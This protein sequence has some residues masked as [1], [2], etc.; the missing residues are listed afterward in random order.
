MRVLVFGGFDFKN[1]QLY[2]VSSYLEVLLSLDAKV[3]IFPLSISAKERIGEY[4][5]DCDCV[6][7]CGGGDVH[8]RFYGK[9]PE[10]GIKKINPLRDEI[11]IEAM[12]LSYEQNKRVLAICRGI[13]VMNVAFG[14]A[15]KQDIDREGYI[16]HFQDM[17]G[18]YGYHRVEI[19]G[20]ILKDIFGC[21]EI[22]VN[23]FHHQ[24]I[25]IKAS[26]FSVEAVAKDGVIEA[27]SRDD[28]D[29]FVGVQWHPEL[30]Y[31]RDCL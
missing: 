17:D 30:M 19:R 5:N 27:I 11:E 23:S 4:I 20:K 9:D 2:V 26:D 16:S 21:E 13:Q 31:I 28:R 1:S 14:G 8:P 6:L 29:F 24:A 15:L 25:D 7:F 18:M 10:R 12:K 22:L 3:I